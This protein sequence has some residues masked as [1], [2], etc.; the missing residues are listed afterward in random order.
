MFIGTIATV[1]ADA[2]YFLWGVF[3]RSK[4][5]EVIEGLS[6]MEPVDM[7][8]DMIGGKELDIERLPEKMDPVNMDIDMIG[9]KDVGRI[10][11][12]V[13][14]DKPITL[15]STS[16]KAEET[17]IISSSHRNLSAL[18]TDHA[19]KI[20]TEYSFDPSVCNA[21]KEYHNP[22]DK[23]DVPPGFGARVW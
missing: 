15:Q 19:K 6:D 5:D 12:I 20:K 21:F 9:G 17:I 2:G 10:D 8:V 18:S 4:I 14:K 1:N 13:R 22:L 23:L 7:D 11:I 16:K 3:R